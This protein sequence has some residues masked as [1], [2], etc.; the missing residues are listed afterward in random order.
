MGLPDWAAPFQGMEFI[1]P[2]FHSGHNGKEVKF[3]VYS[4]IESC[5][6]PSKTLSPF[7]L[8]GSGVGTDISS[9]HHIQLSKGELDFYFTFTFIFS[10]GKR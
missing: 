7:L 4:K 5:P 9:Q 2:Y 8:W 6:V 10:I 1:I 3:I